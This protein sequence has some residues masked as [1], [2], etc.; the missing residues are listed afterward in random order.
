ME[1]IY[2]LDTNVLIHDPNAIFNFQDNMVVVPIY[3]IEE[4]DRLKKDPSQ[5]GVSARIVARKIDNLRKV[6]CLSS[7][8]MLENGG[9]FKVE[10]EGSILE[11]PESL[12]NDVMD[13]RILAVAIHLK[14]IEKNSVILVTKDTNMRI[15]ADS[16]GMLV[17]DYE[18]DNVD[19][20]ELY[21][22]VEEIELPDNE[23]DRFYD[24]GYLN[25]EK[26][27]I[28]K[29]I[30]PNEMLEI[31]SL[32]NPK[33]QA[34]AIK[35]GTSGI[36]ERLIHGE[37]KVWGIKGRNREQRFALELLMD[38]SIKVVT[39]VGKAGTGKTLIALAAALEQVEKGIYKKI[40]IARPIIP[41]GKDIGY[42]PGS[43]K[44]KLRPW[45]QP[46]YDNFDFLVSNRSGD[47]S[48][49]VVSTLENK[50]I[51]KIE[52]LTYIRGRSIPAGFIIV[53]E[54]Q[55]LTPHEVKTIVTR[56]GENTKI[57]F[58]GDPYQIDNPYLDANSNGLTYLADKF[59]AEEI[60]GHITLIKG[61]RS[62][63]AEIAAK[64][65]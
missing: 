6:G 31:V 57:V 11:L 44:E 20:G 42:L 7:G 58:T 47:D 60:S 36:V 17:E 63:L 37:D 13:N 24:L 1:K 53:D 34:L 50:G 5:L 64:L 45:V 14:R 32:A 3:V 49:K 52:A 29:E 43:E 26:L 8:V 25:L 59:K 35:R 33:K 21:T 56:A 41:M 38:Q 12:K 51:L 61:E 55:N 15:K 16:L 19:I 30:Y 54:A 48:E 22:G 2:I 46:I 4:I 10:I 27:E 18:T 9:K 23:I 39:L 40:F 28:K 62:R 65:L